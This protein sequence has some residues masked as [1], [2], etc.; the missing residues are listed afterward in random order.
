MEATYCCYL[1]ILYYSRVRMLSNKTLAP[2]TLKKWWKMQATQTQQLSLC[3]CPR[4]FVGPECKES[5]EHLIEFAAIDAQLNGIAFKPVPDMTFIYYS[6][7]YCKYS[8]WYRLDSNICQV[9]RHREIPLHKSK[10]VWTS[11]WKCNPKPV[12]IRSWRRAFQK[13]ETYLYIAQQSQ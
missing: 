9:Q 4:M 5:V 12:P 11:S 2:K 3:E 7:K 10:T 13:G 1:R 8:Q 6:C